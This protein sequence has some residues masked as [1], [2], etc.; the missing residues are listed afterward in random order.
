MLALFYAEFIVRY[1]AA[2][3][4]Q[5]YTGSMVFCF[6]GALLVGSTILLIPGIYGS[7]IYDYL[8]IFQILRY[9]KISSLLP[10]IP[11]ILVCVFI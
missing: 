2:P 7:R 11:R 3:F 10:R 4:K 9:Y 5:A 1:L 6:D 8:T